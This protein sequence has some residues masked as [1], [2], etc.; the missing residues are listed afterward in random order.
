MLSFLAL[1]GATICLSGLCSGGVVLNKNRKKALN[2][3]WFLFST[4]VALWGIIMAVAIESETYAMAYRLSWWQ[5]AVA[6]PIPPLFL[7]LILAFT[8]RLPARKKLLAGIYV[9]PC[10]YLA[11]ILACPNW[12]ISSATLRFEQF[13]YAD[14]GPIYWVFILMYGIYITIGM[15]V[16]ISFILS[17]HKN[18]GIYSTLLLGFSVGFLGGAT[19]FP[20]LYGY[21][22]YPFGT[23]GVVVYL[24]ICGYAFL[25]LKFFDLTLYFIQIFSK[26]LFLCLVAVSF[27]II[28]YIKNTL[29]ITE[30]VYLIP[31]VFW[32]FLSG[33][34]W[35][36]I[37]QTV[38]KQILGGYYQLDNVL[39]NLSQRLIRAQSQ[40][41]VLSIIQESLG[42]IFG[43]SQSIFL[44]AD[45]ELGYCLY[46]NQL[47]KT[48]ITLAMETDIL[49]VLQ[50]MQL[51]V[52]VSSLPVSVHNRLNF[53]RIYPQELCI[54]I[55]SSN[56]YIGIMILGTKGNA[57]TYNRGDR[58][59][60]HAMLGQAQVI[61][62]RIDYQDKLTT[63]TASQ[64]DTISIQEE[65]LKRKAEM[66]RDLSRAEIAQQKM[67]PQSD[68]HVNDFVIHSVFRP[69]QK[70][71]GDF[72]NYYVYSKTKV[73]ILI[74]D[75]VGKRFEAAMSMMLAKPIFDSILSTEKPPHVAMNEV[76]Q[77]YIESGL[78]HRP[79]PAIF[80]VLDTKARTATYANAG[81]EPGLYFD[82]QT[83]SEFQIGFDLIGMELDEVYQSISLTLSNFDSILLYTDG[84][85]D[86]VSESGEKLS[87]D[88]IYHII[89][90]NKGR[91]GT[92]PIAKLIA[93][94]MATI[95]H[96]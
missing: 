89:K 57:R 86:V 17:Q 78:F 85:T 52:L 59:L 53:L 71:S 32:A 87:M 96:G 30:T 10:I 68:P 48:D 82:G 75:I 72:F 44:L 42:N 19:T 14:A 37:D 40:C 24:F 51:P 11:T 47:K 43:T 3:I 95:Q 26:V 79:T 73:G 65:Q 28:T 66:D 39:L 20:L 56:H 33:K 45:R 38:T 6:I 8:H 9:G 74:A 35:L 77:A 4:T 90:H 61:F 29:S 81:F 12:F 13:Y 36:Y 92:P 88:E 50:S 64:K 55:R 18:T 22:L 93:E 94:K 60:I 63:I 2:I 5:S 69:A 27:F 91:H 67:L 21:P 23:W 70:V 16:L 46:N 1:S 41:D 54:P 58:M 7:H 15:I 76:N 62:D 83:F 31:L 49:A 34:I 80:L 84:L 25:H